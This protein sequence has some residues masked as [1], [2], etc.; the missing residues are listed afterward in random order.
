MM[1]KYMIINATLCL[2]HFPFTMDFALHIENK[3]SKFSVLI[4]AFRGHLYG[5]LKCFPSSEK[6]INY[7]QIILLPLDC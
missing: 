6:L 1:F 3:K 5:L 4:S 7:V 2:K